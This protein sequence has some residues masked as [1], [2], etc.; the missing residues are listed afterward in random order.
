MRV[1]VMTTGKKLL[2]MDDE[3]GDRRG[4]SRAQYAQE[5]EESGGLPSPGNLLRGI[6]GR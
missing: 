6:F 2:G 4:S 1:R 3:D 5:K